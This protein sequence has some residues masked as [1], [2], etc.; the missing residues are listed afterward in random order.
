MSRVIIALP[1]LSR[2]RRGQTRPFRAFGRVGGRE[3]EREGGMFALPAI[4]FT[5]M[6]FYFALFVVTGIENI[7]TQTEDTG[8][9]LRNVFSK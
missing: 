5:K 4:G 7:T 6:S 3:G 8:P 2:T 1:H 9:I